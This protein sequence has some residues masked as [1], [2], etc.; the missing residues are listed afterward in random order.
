MDAESVKEQNKYSRMWAQSKYDEQS[1][2]LYGLPMAVALIGDAKKG[3]TFVDFGCGKG[4]VLDALEMR[5][6]K[7]YG[8]DLVKLHDKA[9]VASLWELPQSLD[10]ADYGLSFDVLEHLPTD[11]VPAALRNMARMFKKK[12][13]FQICMREDS[14]G[15]LIGEKLHLTVQDKKWW[16]TQLSEYFTIVSESI[17]PRYHDTCIFVV[18]PK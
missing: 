14:M 1:P 17:H 15:A 18:K 16:S 3:D 4:L 5:G 10:P 11:K 13:F 7:A 9:I 6:Y 2:G 12:G 8:I